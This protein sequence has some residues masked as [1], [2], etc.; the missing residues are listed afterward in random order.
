MAEEFEIKYKPEEID[1]ADDVDLDILEAIEKKTQLTLDQIHKMTKI[2][3]DFLR[4]RLNAL[5][6]AGKLNRSR[7]GNYIFY[8]LTKLGRTRKKDK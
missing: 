3:R 4:N 1:Y 7:I 5:T 6:E 2:R 8:S